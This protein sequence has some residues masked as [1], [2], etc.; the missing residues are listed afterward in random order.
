[1]TRT[2]PLLAL[3]LLTASAPALAQERTGEGARAARAAPAARPAPPSRPATP[4]ARPGAAAGAPRGG[5]AG[6]GAYERNYPGGVRAAPQAGAAAGGRAYGF[7]RPSTAAPPAGA[8][9]TG[10]VSP[11][12]RGRAFDAPRQ[13]FAGDPG[14]GGGGDFSGRRQADFGARGQGYSGARGGFSYNGRQYARFHAEPF[15]FPR[16][17]SY[18]YYGRGQYLPRVYLYDSFFLNDYADFYLSPPP[19]P[20]YRW[21]R[22]GPDALLVDVDTGQVVDAAYGVFDDGQSYGA[23]PGYGPDEDGYGYGGD[24]RAA[25]PAY[26]RDPYDRDGPSPYGDARPAYGDPRDGGPDGDGGYGPPPR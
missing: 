13:G 7:D 16:G 1:M 12:A 5:F 8:T 4:T 20:E 18:R 2:A 6:Y 9:S 24:D 3:A 21:V 23:A 22:Y 15:R 26:E 19:G 11:G 14:R 25:P 17:Y 10:A